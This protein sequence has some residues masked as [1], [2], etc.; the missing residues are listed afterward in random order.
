MGEN[1]VD[2]YIIFPE[3]R[4]KKIEHV[5]FK[6]FLT[7]GHTFAPDLDLTKCDKSIENNAR[8]RKRN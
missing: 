1:F 3:I 2:F 6:Y 7:P 5:N 4:R 8:K